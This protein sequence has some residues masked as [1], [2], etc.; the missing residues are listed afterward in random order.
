MINYF[1]A[2]D[3]VYR[4]LACIYAAN[5]FQ[6]VTK[7]KEKRQTAASCRINHLLA[8]STLVDMKLCSFHSGEWL[9]CCNA[10]EDSEIA[11]K[12]RKNRKR[13]LLY[14][15]YKIHTYT[16]IYYKTIHVFICKMP[17]VFYFPNRATLH[18]LA[19]TRK[20]EAWEQKKMRQSRQYLFRT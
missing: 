1:S 16:H 9:S 5:T 13:Q 14:I 12:G 15:L 20:S 17:W 18:S 8:T 11:V 4:S 6:L 10:C 2:S 3:P 19:G 7:K